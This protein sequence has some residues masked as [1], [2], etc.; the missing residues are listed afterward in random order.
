VH[1]Y[2]RGFKRVVVWLGQGMLDY[3]KPT[4]VFINQNVARGIRKAVPRL[5]TLLENFYEQGDRQRHFF[6]KVEVPL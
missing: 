1:I 6:A 3:D 2:A 4:K 5:E